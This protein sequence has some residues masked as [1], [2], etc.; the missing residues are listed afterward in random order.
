MNVEFEIAR[1]TRANN[2]LAGKMGLIEEDFYAFQAW[3]KEAI[4]FLAGELL[5]IWREEKP[6]PN[7]IKRI[8]KQ[9]RLF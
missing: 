3:A 4:Q 8:Q 7:D 5:V 6:H 9:A 2:E 1:L